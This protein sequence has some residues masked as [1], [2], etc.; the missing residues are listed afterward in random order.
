[1]LLLLRMVPTA[2]RGRSPVSLLGI[3]VVVIVAMRLL[4]QLLKYVGRC[5]GGGCG[6]GAIIIIVIV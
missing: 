3:I 1:M 6:V 4:L 5:V 2:L